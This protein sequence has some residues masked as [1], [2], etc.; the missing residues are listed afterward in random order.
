MFESGIF[1]DDL[2]FQIIPSV[3]VI[4]GS[5]VYESVQVGLGDLPE[6]LEELKQSRLPFKLDSQS[7]N[8]YLN[9]VLDSLEKILQNEYAAGEESPNDSA[10]QFSLQASPK[11]SPPAATQ[12]VGLLH[13][14]PAP[15]IQT[16]PP[17][18]L[19]ATVD[20]L[21][22]RIQVFSEQLREA[23]INRDTP[24][25]SDPL[26]LVTD[27]LYLD[28]GVGALPSTEPYSEEMRI[29]EVRMRAAEVFAKE[30][31]GAYQLA[32]ANKLSRTG[33]RTG[34]NWITGILPDQLHGKTL[35][36]S[37]KH[38]L[39]DRK[40]ALMV[41]GNP[42]KRLKPKNITNKWVITLSWEKEQE[43]LK[44]DDLMLRTSLLDEENGE[45]VT[46]PE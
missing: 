32:L 31:E 3:E 30:A 24:I 25:Q 8:D 17:Q 6:L 35:T 46:F 44:S 27:G 23:I 37:L 42:K 26:M 12:S 38:P 7:K 40:W 11:A 2:Q 14:P 22:R 43:W 41:D 15:L 34:S 10:K 16:E 33:S 9:G 29:Q 4:A 5:G 19:G 20:D 21:H 13:F 18:A 36:I 39:P 28:T 45:I 1:L